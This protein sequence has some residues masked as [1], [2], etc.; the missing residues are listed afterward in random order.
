MTRYFFD[1]CD[2]GDVAVDTV[3]F[4]LS[5]PEIAWIEAAMSAV[6]MARDKTG[7]PGGNG[8]ITAVDV[9]DKR[10]PVM[11]VKVT[12]ETRLPKAAGKPAANDT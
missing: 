4:E 12:L 9:R 2:G 3:G 10:G 6:E 11:S 8:H 1:V 5:T 7:K